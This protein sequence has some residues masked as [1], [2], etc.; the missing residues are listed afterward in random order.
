VSRARRAQQV[1]FDISESFTDYFISEQCGVE[2][3][4]TISGHLKATVRYNQAGLVVSEIDRQ[5]S[6]RITYSS[7]DTGRSFS[8]PNAVPSH[9]DYG[10]GAAIGSA[11]MVKF[12][13][14]YGHV[15][16]LIA[17]DAGPGRGDRRGS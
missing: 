11:V 1:G 3:V 7:P 8:F 9:W 5:P 10:T 17:S 15:P 2:V 6:S 14:M 16:G 12:A 4:V 13:G